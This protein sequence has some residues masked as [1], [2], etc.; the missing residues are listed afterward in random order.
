MKFFIFLIFFIQILSDEDDYYSNYTSPCEKIGN[1]SNFKDC[2]GKACEFIEEKCCYLESKNTTTG[3]T[4]KECIDFY[5]YDYM[6]D[7]LKEKA[8]EAIKNGTYWEGYNETYD[9]I[10]SLKCASE[11]LFQQIILYLLILYF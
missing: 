6:R 2:I 7:D 9:E 10:I 3:I 1:P 5:F 8:I 4:L 11:F